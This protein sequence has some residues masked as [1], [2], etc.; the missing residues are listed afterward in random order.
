M[1][2]CHGRKIILFALILLLTS[3]TAFGY[4]SNNWQHIDSEH[5]RISY[6]EKTA[7]LAHPAME[8]AEEMARRL[9]DYFGKDISSPKLAIVLN[10][11]NDLAN[12]G[13]YRNKP[14]ITIECRKIEPNNW[15]GSMTLK[16]LISHE[17]S[18][19]YS[20]RIM[21]SKFTL[22][23]SAGYSSPGDGTYTSANGLYTHNALPIWFVEGLAQVG[24]Y[25]VDADYRDPYREMLLRDALFNNKLLSIDEMSRFEGTARESELAYN[26]GFDLLLYLVNGYPAITLK[27]LCKDVRK[28]G[29]E[30]SIQKN[31]GVS[32]EQLYAKWHA[33]LKAR[34]SGNATK[35]DG[36]R[37]YNFI[38]NPMTVEVRSAL[39][40]KYV[41][42]NWDH[43][44]LRFDLM[45]LDDERRS[46]VKVERDVGK[47]L[48]RDPA[49]GFIWFNRSKYNWDTGTVNY[50]IYKIDD[51]GI[52]SR[53]TTGERCLAF[54]VKN[55]H[56]MYAAYKHGTTKV[57]SRQPNNTF[58]ELRSF[59]Y[60][61]SVHSISMLSER[62]AVLTIDDGDHVT[63]ALLN[64]N[65]F[66]ILWK[67]LNYDIIDAVSAGNQRLVFVST[68]DNSPQLYWCD[69]KQ[70]KNRW[71]KITS[72]AGG[73]RYPETGPE[74]NT[75]DV[76]CSVY[77]NGAF[78]RYTLNN[79]FTKNQPVDIP[80]KN[81]ARHRVD[82]A[83]AIPAAAPSVTPVSS[84]FIISDPVYMLSFSSQKDAGASL[85]PGVR[86]AI[87][88]APDN[89]AF[90]VDGTV[91]MPFDYHTDPDPFPAYSLWSEYNLWQFKFRFSHSVNASLS[92]SIY[93][94]V[95]NLS[96]YRQRKNIQTS[97]RLSV[98]FQITEHDFIT[99]AYVLMDNRI[100][101]ELEL[102]SGRENP[103]LGIDKDTSFTSYKASIKQLAWQH[104]VTKSKFDPADLGSP[105]YSASVG[106]NFY[107]NTY[108]TVDSDSSV[109]EINLAADGLLLLAD[110]RLSVKC[111]FNFFS[112]SNAR[113]ANEDIASMYTPIG[114]ENLFSGYSP[115]I[116]VT[117]L[118]RLHTELRFNPFLSV[119][120]RTQWF[121]RMHIGFK[122]EAGSVDYLYR[123][124]KND[125]ALS[126]ELALRYGFYLRPNRLSS[127]YLKYAMPL[128]EIDDIDQDPSAK[129][130]LGVSIR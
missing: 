28:L 34:F 85:A 80:P 77:E 21:Q 44:F 14:L 118:Y 126:C 39:K 60:G 36:S 68:R 43:D 63:A 101:Q 53:V 35:I 25:S 102:R 72:V 93:F 7:H 20:L 5:I 79:P 66:E 56:V 33:S 17:M 128:K 86:L 96:Y 113:R 61:T 13:A 31:Y 104:S 69:M 49:S 123:G 82:K 12:G 122:L 4:P 58:T 99:G 65:G 9:G 22:L 6:N 18:H 97:N 26:Q 129:I 24:S 37:L 38:N 64:E 108:P 57:I 111:G 47:V 19:A 8:I 120:D 117:E 3:A 48:K 130:Y 109:N 87:S 115:L 42:A 78:L 2:P 59:P 127:V 98:D 27:A 89:I 125:L 94:P 88:N 52:D 105:Y 116:L 81:G 74:S 15:R 100:E 11:H 119:F 40:G 75:K 91:T 76:T 107:D 70:N 45:V 95:E 41:T 62:S 67:G 46:I 54:D 112:F 110:R 30:R 29:F 121:E 1:K 32:I 90:G 124:I 23:S 71:Y 51:K 73:I 83:V 10:D 50:D 106:I 16:T 55:D 92:E 114:T 84:N 103:G